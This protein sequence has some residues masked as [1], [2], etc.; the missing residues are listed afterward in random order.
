M[1]IVVKTETQDQGVLEVMAAKYPIQIR[2]EGRSIRMATWSFEFY[3]E[4]V[5][6]GILEGVVIKDGM[7]GGFFKLRQQEDAVQVLV[8]DAKKLD[9][10][11]SYSSKEFEIT[12]EPHYERSG[13]IDLDAGKPLTFRQE[14]VLR[15]FL[16]SHGFA[17]VNT[18]RYKITCTGVKRTYPLHTAAKRVD[19]TVLRYLL[20]A[21]AEANQKDSRKRTALDVARHYNYRGSHN[22]TIAQLALRKAWT[23]ADDEDFF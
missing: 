5:S 19:D 16:I 22:G 17:S 1:D 6:S 10:D 11:N 7:T 23:K 2:W 3:G 18:P 4:E 9:A 8:Q 15:E 20:E 12:A 13:C 21:K 14:I